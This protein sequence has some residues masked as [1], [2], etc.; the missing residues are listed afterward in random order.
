EP[1][2]LDIFYQATDD[3]GLTSARLE[4]E[5]RRAFTTDPVEGSRTLTTPSVGSTEHVDWNLEELDLRPRDR[6]RFR[7]TVRDN[8]GWNGFKSAASPWHTLEV[9]SMSAFFEETDRKERNVQ[10]ALDEVSDNYRQMQEEYE[11]FREQ[12]RENPEP[13]WEE[14]QM[15]EDVD[16][17]QRE[18]EES[19]NRVKEQFEEIRREM[20]NSS[21]V[22]NETRQSYQELQELIDELD[23]PEIRRALEELR[24]S[25]QNLNPEELQ[26]AMENF[27]FNEKVYRERLERTLELFK[28]LKMNSDLDK[29]ARQYEE[30][31]N[32]MN[33]VVT[34]E[35]QTPGEERDQQQGVRED[36]DHI[37]SQ[38]ENLDKRPPERSRERLEQ[39]KDESLNELK[40]IQQ[41]LD[42]LI[43]EAANRQDGSSN[44]SGE[45]SGDSSTNSANSGEQNGEKES[46]GGESEDQNEETSREGSET[47]G[48][49]ETG[50]SR[51]DQQAREQQ[52]SVRD[53][54]QQRAKRLRQSRQQMGGRQIQ[55][56]LLALQ[57]SL[58]TLLELSEAQEELTRETEQ[59]DSRS[60]GY[61]ELA[62]RQNNIKNQFS[63]VSDSLFQ[64]ASEIPHLSNTINRKKNEV[65]Q[66]L[67]RAREQ[68]A[69]RDQPNSVITSRESLGGINDLASMIA[70]V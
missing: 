23:D 3:F 10:D 30:L 50:R 54:L 65:E 14:D 34:D 22:S 20:E 8:D 32:R 57:R 62:Q 42:E 53:R 24:E 31:A 18:I 33:E 41:D 12:M 43:E 13:G 67:L 5:L 29:L 68:M 9:P 19:I 47:G 44:D 59:T 45:Q 37:E 35:E 46:D 69:D 39:L 52:E 56:N 2:Q 63:Q 4:W 26:R 7:I 21:A 36:T 61:V 48:Q 40:G 38:L 27:E 11:R 17:Q 6:L 1:E 55:V 66:T 49:G 16:R 60:Q 58:Y 25:M 64:I 70:S 28:T 51:S 15:L